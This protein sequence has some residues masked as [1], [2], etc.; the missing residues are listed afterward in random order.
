MRRLSNAYFIK[1][2]ADIL[3]FVFTDRMLCRNFF[4]YPFILGYLGK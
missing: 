2:K 3:S 1:A 4:N